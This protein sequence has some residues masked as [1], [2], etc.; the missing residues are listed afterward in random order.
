MRARDK[1]RKGWSDRMLQIICSHDFMVGS[2]KQLR[3]HGYTCF[4]KSSTCNLKSVG[5]I[6][7]QNIFDLCVPDGETNSLILTSFTEQRQLGSIQHVFIRLLNVNQ[8]PLLEQVGDH[9]DVNRIPFTASFIAK[10]HLP[11]PLARSKIIGL[12]DVKPN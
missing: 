4:T 11:Q 7:Q 5:F 9:C 2:A 8:R 10:F 12:L 6:Y 3:L 1:K